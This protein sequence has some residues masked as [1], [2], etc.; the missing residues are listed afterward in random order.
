MLPWSFSAKAKCSMRSFKKSSEYS[1]ELES[2]QAGEQSIS[3][4]WSQKLSPMIR[5]DQKASVKE[6]RKLVFDHTRTQIHRASA[7]IIKIVRATLLL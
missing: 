4:R 7:C 6:R 3:C 1:G 2:L 5:Q